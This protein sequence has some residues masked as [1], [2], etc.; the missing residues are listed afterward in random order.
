MTGGFVDR[1]SSDLLHPRL[2]GMMRDTG[3]TH[4]SGLKIKEKQNVVRG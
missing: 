2:C 4:A 1:V 3:Q